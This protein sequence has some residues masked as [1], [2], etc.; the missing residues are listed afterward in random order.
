MHDFRIRNDSKPAAAATTHQEEV[1]NNNISTSTFCYAIR[2]MC[3]KIF[4][5]M[6]ALL[7][8][9][10]EAGMQVEWIHAMA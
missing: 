3:N 4:I 6:C 1:N 9:C 5:P 7:L 2:K 10:I 8:V